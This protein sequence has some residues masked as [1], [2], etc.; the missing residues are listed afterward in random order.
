MASSRCHDNSDVIVTLI[1]SNFHLY[2]IQL[3]GRSL[4]SNLGGIDPEK[5][6]RATLKGVVLR[7]WFERNRQKKF[8]LL[9]ATISTIH[10]VKEFKTLSYELHLKLGGDLN[11]G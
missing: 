9:N 4:C 8:S 7:R 11:L 3:W 1:I 10:Y 2:L 6:Y 5:P